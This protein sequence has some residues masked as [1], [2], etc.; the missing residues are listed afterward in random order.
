MHSSKYPVKFVIDFP[1]EINM[2]IP[3]SN[4]QKY[5]YFGVKLTSNVA[6][7]LQVNGR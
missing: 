7:F 1:K 4:V 5:V 2:L 3:I 6:T